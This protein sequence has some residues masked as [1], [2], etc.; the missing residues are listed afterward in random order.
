M[1]D[2]GESRK[3]LGL[4]IN[5]SFS[6][7]SFFLH[8]QKYTEEILERFGIQNSH[9]VSTSLEVSSK[10]ESEPFLESSEPVIYVP[11]HQA[12]GIIMYLMIG[13]RPDLAFVIRKLFQFLEKP[14]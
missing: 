6:N 11:Y 4:E 9:T 7:Y 14:L 2:M 3:V 5:R 10:S 1:N 8:Q 12:F 13:T